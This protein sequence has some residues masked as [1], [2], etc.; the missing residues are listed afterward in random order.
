MRQQSLD[1]WNKKPWVNST[2]HGRKILQTPVDLWLLSE[3]IDKSR[4]GLIVELGVLEGGL[5]LWLNFKTQSAGIRCRII[6][7]DHKIPQDVFTSHSRVAERLFGIE[8][9][10][11][12]VVTIDWV[13]KT[14]KAI[15]DGAFP[16]IDPAAPRIV[17]L[18]DDHDPD[19]VAIELRTYAKFCRLGDWLIVCD[20]VPV[21][22]LEGVSR[23]F[24]KINGFEVLGLDRFGLSNH[25]G[26]WLRKQ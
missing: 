7:V 21:D 18:D 26:G 10:V 2:F 14:I 17:I 13:G 9:D 6:G 20:T 3:L 12:D 15:D 25:R 19:H 22:G 1:A 16:E 8:G 23:S 11:L 24:A 4:P 5:S